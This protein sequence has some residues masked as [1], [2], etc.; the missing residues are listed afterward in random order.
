MK[1]FYA[2]RQGK[3]PGIYDTW[4]ECKKQVNGYK[5]AEFKGFDNIDEAKNYILNTTTQQVSKSDAIAYVD[6][7]YC[8]NTQRF[9]YGAVLFYEGKELHF[10]DSFNDI[11]LSSMRNVAGEIKGAEFIMNY[12]ILNNIKSIDLYYDYEGIEKWCTGAWK[13]TK[14]GTINYADFYNKIK[15][16]LSV[17]FIKVKGH[18]NNKYNDLADYLAKSALGIN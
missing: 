9:S 6:G 11:Q 18:S 14:P 5:N 7:S 13:A 10:S 15:N 8:I 12:C 2:V 4:D 3:I 16:D 1:K 17:T